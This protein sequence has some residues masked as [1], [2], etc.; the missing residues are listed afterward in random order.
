MKKIIVTIIVVVV[1]AGVY[2]VYTKT[3]CL[4]PYQ[5]VFVISQDSSGTISDAKQCKYVGWHSR[6]S[7]PL[8]R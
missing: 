2:I 6:Y 3:N 1:L 8:N 7:K 4:K 5:E